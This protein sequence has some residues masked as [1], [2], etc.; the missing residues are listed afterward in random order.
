MRIVLGETE[1]PLTIQDSEVETSRHT[2]RE[3]RRLQVELVVKG[4]AAEE[5]LSGALEQASDAPI[6]LVADSG[7]ADGQWI[8]F[9]QSS[10][11]RDGVPIYR[12]VL[13]LKE[14]EELKVAALQVAGL[15]LE[16]YAYSEEFDGEALVVTARV[17]VDRDQQDA[18]F[19][20]EDRYFPVVRVGLSEEPRMMR[21]GR[22][23]WSREQQTIQ[24]E[25]V[26]VDQAYDED[27]HV[28][29]HA[30]DEPSSSHL[31]EMALEDSELLCTLC[32][33]LAESGA[34]SSEGL[35]QLTPVLERLRTRDSREFLRVK[36]LEEW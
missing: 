30:F 29:R 34:V 2:G 26:L 6:G 16:P 15:S 31:E 14:W 12:H 4:E 25:L 17:T 19:G 18:L 23:L 7:E 35:A 20:Q 8:I 11:Y 36:D 32:D 33:L 22:C 1:L 10:S 24:Q 13:E 27:E 9:E 5:Q 21:M 28:L 3:L